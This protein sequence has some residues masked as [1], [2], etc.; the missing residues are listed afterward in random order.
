MVSE[1]EAPVSPPPPRDLPC[2]DTVL[3]PLAGKIIQ[4][5]SQQRQANHLKELHHNESILIS[6]KHKRDQTY[7]D[8]SLCKG[9][10]NME[11]IWVIYEPIFVPSCGFNQKGGFHVQRHC[12]SDQGPLRLW[13]LPKEAANATEQHALPTGGYQCYLKIT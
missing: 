5:L 4:L 6:L 3:K 7:T 1:Q 13:L 2:Q 10:K 12:S 11:K 9:G 8:L